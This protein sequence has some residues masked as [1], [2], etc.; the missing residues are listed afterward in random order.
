[1]PSLIR[2]AATSMGNVPG[3]SVKKSASRFWNSAPESSR[4]GSR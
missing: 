2:V 1:L 3:A 4:L